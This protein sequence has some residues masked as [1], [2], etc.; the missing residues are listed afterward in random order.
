MRRVEASRPG[1]RQE[2]SHRQE[3]PK[4][5]GSTFAFHWHYNRFTQ[6]MQNRRSV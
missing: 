1:G 4:L 5:T 3:D 2:A 6:A